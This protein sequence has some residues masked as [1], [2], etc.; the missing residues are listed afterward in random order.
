MRYSPASI[1]RL[2]VEASNGRPE[3]LHGAALGFLNP[4]NYVLRSLIRSGQLHDRINAL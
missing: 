4:G 1:L 2:P 3:H